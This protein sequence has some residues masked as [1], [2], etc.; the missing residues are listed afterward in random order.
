[1]ST[2]RLSMSPVAVNQEATD[3]ATIGARSPAAPFDGRRNRARTSLTPIAVSAIALVGLALH[4]ARRPGAVLRPVLFAE[5]GQVFLAGAL[6]DGIRGLFEPY[7]GYL[8]VGPRL[9][10]FAA[11]IVS[12]RHI[13]LAFA[14]I[15]A[16]YSVGCCSLVLST[17]V[18]WLLGSLPRR[19]AVFVALLLL[20]Q[21][22]ETHATLTNVMWWGGIALLI[23]GLSDDPGTWKG[24]VAEA[25]I[26]ASVLLSGPIGIV[27]SP[28]AAWR[29][30]RL[31][32]RWSLFITL[33]WAALCLTQLLVLRGQDRDVGNV[34]IGRETAAVFV[35]RWFGPFTVDSTYVQRRL[36]GPAWSAWAWWRTVMFM[37][38][39]VAIATLALS[40][41]ARERAKNELRT[42]GGTAPLLLLGLGAL[43]VIAGFVAM[44]KLALLLPDRYTVGAGAAL[45]LAVAACAVPRFRPA[46]VLYALVLLTALIVWPRNVAVPD[47][48]GPSF[49][50]A[51]RCLATEDQICQIPVIPEPFSFQIGPESR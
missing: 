24:R 50:D 36:A 38:A 16:A 48:V 5:D 18:A 12:A 23:V 4:L 37:V 44:G 40:L 46:R 13:P 2:A 33:Q 34:P 11:T 1:M 28:I 7:A 19:V 10:A 49:D 25:L 51:G 15:A 22:A 30:L 47:R 35:R 6:R 20:P 14:L 27:F 9:G 32:T 43:H 3:G 21:V 29:L 17:R 31:R 8:V 42:L 39:V 26:I 45:V 41:F